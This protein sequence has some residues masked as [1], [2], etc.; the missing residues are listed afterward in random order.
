MKK[1]L[2]ILL[3]TA[4][5]TAALGVCALAA[6]EPTTAGIYGINGTGATLT[7]KTA[8]DGSITA[9]NTN[10]D[11]S[12][13]YAD[14]VKFTVS[15]KDLTAGSQYLLLVVKGT[16][17]DVTVTA[18]TI[19]Y[20]DQAAAK[21]DGKV[22]FT[23]YPSALTKG[24]YSVYIIGANKAFSAG[25]AAT[26]SYYQPYTLG[27]VDGDGNININDAMKVM[28][29]IAGIATLNETQQLAANVV[30]G[31]ADDALNINDAMQIIYFI[32]EKIDKF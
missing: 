31:G 22:E 12:G 14:A 27:D 3:L 21:S 28:Y 4:L 1:L 17:A 30:T 5:L 26:F 23:A 8:A 18:D 16:G 19:V 10:A 32:V 6:D 9:D 11:Y 20:I 24:S 2:R 15:A 7:P 25:P 29:H 13:Y